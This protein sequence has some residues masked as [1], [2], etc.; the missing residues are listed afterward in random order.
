M[1]KIT[2]DSLMRAACAI[3]PALVL[4]LANVYMFQ[5]HYVG[6]ATFPWDFLGGYHA[7]SFGWFDRSTLVSPPTWFA[8]SSMGFP[9]FLALQSGAWYLPLVLLHLSGVAYT[10]HVATVVQALHV[11]FGAVGAYALLRRLGASR[12]IALVGGLGFHFGVAFYCNQ[13]HV[14]I[15]R[16]TA[17]LPWVLFALHPAAFERRRWGVLVGALALS[18]LLIAGYPG[19]LVSSVYACAAW[20]AVSGWEQ[21][22]RGELR[23]YVG[24]LF[25]TV[26][27]G[28]LIAMPK[29]L[30]LALNGM[31]GLSIDHLPTE[32]FVRA[33]LLTLVM[34]YS[35]EKL[36]GNVTMRSVWLP[37]ASMAGIAFA[38]FRS[39]TFWQ[40]GV[41]VILALVMGLAVQGSPTWSRLVPGLQVSRFPISDWRPVLTLGLIIAS[42]HGWHRLVSGEFSSGRV[43]LRSMLL[44]SVCLFV[45]IKAASYGYP[46][47]DFKRPLLALW[48]LVMATCCLPFLRNRTGNTLRS[49]KLLPFILIAAAGFD[50]VAYQRSQRATWQPP[51]DDQ[52]E[53]LYLGG[54]VA[55]FIQKGE[56][57]PERRA[58]RPARFVE[59]SGVGDALANRN[60]LMNNRCWYERSYC[61]FGYDNLRISQPHQQFLAAL[62][63]LGGEQLLSFVSGPQQI[64][65]LEKTAGTVG[66]VPM[67]PKSTDAAVGATGGVDVAF[68]DYGQDTVTYRIITPR[69]VTM[70]EN[71]L[72]WPGWKLTACSPS[73]A[74]TDAID[75]R[76]TSQ[77][78]RSWDVPPGSWTM[79]LHFVGPSSLPGYVCL[80]LG[81]IIAIFASFSWLPVR[82][83]VTARGAASQ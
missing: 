21:W 16:A 45:V 73:G 39:R 25:I 42:T 57:E 23:G 24:G 31:S 41:L 13:E 47:A 66:S 75:T 50:G 68:V 18:Q 81:L 58:R 67:I 53:R 27:S 14:D 59:G 44:L 35:L 20:V 28:T 55:D 83:W 6:A 48:I 46:A 34:P 15:V 22:N 26:L 4:V 3:G 65:V 49:W 1:K 10:I 69:A 77:F 56:S 2:S 33:H 79:H 70:V 11:L 37:M 30:P 80:I 7:Q 8:S 36:P 61:V 63:A 74:C 54:T 52:S 9:A 17:W 76:P 51:W 5:L 71:E 72:W 82:Q 64:L 12:S 43:V 60:S 40:G 19:N 38:N 29:W 32:P 62:S 78:L